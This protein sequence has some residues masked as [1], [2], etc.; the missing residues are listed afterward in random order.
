MFIISV[1]AK[2]LSPMHFIALDH[3]RIVIGTGYKIIARIL[4]HILIK[5][6]QVKIFYSSLLF[7]MTLK[8]IVKLLFNNNFKQDNLYFELF[9]KLQFDCKFSSYHFESSLFPSVIVLLCTSAAK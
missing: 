2:Y 7:P 6:K 9:L 3:K 8:K 1:H 4:L 5:S